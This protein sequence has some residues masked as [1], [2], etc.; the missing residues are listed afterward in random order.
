MNKRQLQILS[1]NINGK[2]YLINTKIFHSF[3]YDYDI[4]YLCETHCSKD[5]K[6]NLDGYKAYQ[7]P[8]KVSKKENPR[9][10]VI[11]YL[12]ENIAKHVIDSNMELNDT[13]TLY[14]NNNTTLCG[15]YMLR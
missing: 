7:N 15:M 3:I 11:L 12:K 6:I 14:M 13:I 4:V 2:F 1:W 9:G 5:M 8:C 10:G